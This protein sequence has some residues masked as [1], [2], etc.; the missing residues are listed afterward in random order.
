[1]RKLI[2]VFL[3]AGVLGATGFQPAV[4][5]DA[6]SLDQLL[7]QVRSGRSGD[8]E[9]NAARIRE[10]QADRAR[11]SQLLQEA[12]GERSRGEALSAQLEAQFDSNDTELVEL[13]RQ[14][15]D[16]LGSLKELFGVLQ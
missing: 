8:A 15:Q 16:R 11:Q 7:Q 6:V 9:A 10:F 2:S 3:A 4:A 13:E 5:A 12:R 1:M 14:L